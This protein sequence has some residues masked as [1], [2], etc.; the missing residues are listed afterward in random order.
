MLKFMPF[1]PSEQEL[2]LYV[3]SDNK[4]IT[5]NISL[6]LESNQLTS[7]IQSFCVDEK[8]ERQVEYWLRHHKRLDKVPFL[9]PDSLFY[10]ELILYL[11][12]TFEET[13]TEAL[14]CRT[15]YTILKDL[16][17]LPA[18]AISFI[19]LSGDVPKIQLKFTIH[20]TCFT[21]TVEVDAYYPQRILKIDAKLPGTFVQ[22]SYNWHPWKA[23][24]SQVYSE[25]KRRILKMNE[26]MN[27]VIRL[28]KEED[29]VIV[30]PTN[31]T[32]FESVFKILLDDDDLLI[33]L[34][35]SESIFNAGKT[36]ILRV[37][38]KNPSR[39]GIE[40]KISTFLW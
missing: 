22:F 20:E 5:I 39:M 36:P 4:S 12:Q 3:Y 40:S 34:N 15:K 33:A 24:I 31:P 17:C 13:S 28:I 16:E 38:G 23:S 14:S 9:S 37:E 7:R 25:F 2:F 18:E 8:V 6:D 27:Y 19:N 10:Q 26:Y 35:I 21:L 11:H 29:L 32:L 1:F 30:E